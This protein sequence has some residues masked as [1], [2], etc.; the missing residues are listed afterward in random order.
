MKT[1]MQTAATMSSRHA[2]PNTS[3]AM[4]TGMMRGF[5]FQYWSPSSTPASTST[6]R[7]SRRFTQSG[8]PRSPGRV[9]DGL[10]RPMRAFPSPGRRVLPSE[11]LR[12]GQDGD[13]I[14]V[15]RS[16]VLLHASQAVG[17]REQGDSGG[18]GRGALARGQAPDERVLA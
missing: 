18:P 11:P 15:V 12:R 10:R 13:V 9:A 1:S 8:P 4:M 3:S 2:T 7:V 14:D 6:A 16:L 5:G 17:Q